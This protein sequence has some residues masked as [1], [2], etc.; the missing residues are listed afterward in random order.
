MF[1]NDNIEVITS[2][3]CF[4]LV[5]THCVSI[6]CVVIISLRHTG[7]VV[8]DHTHK[9]RP[10]D[11]F[12]CCEHCSGWQVE[13][14]SQPTSS[15]KSKDKMEERES[16]S[17]CYNYNA[18]VTNNYY[19][20]PSAPPTA[21]PTCNSNSSCER[22]APLNAPS[23]QCSKSDDESHNLKRKSHD[24]KHKIEPSEQYSRK[25]DGGRARTTLSRKST[26]CIGNG[27]AC[28]AH[29]P[30]CTRSLSDSS[31][32]LKQRCCV[33]HGECFCEGKLSCVGPTSSGGGSTTKS[34][35]EE[36]GDE[37]KEMANRLFDVF[38]YN[39]LRRNY[40]GTRKEVV[41]SLLV[42]FFIYQAVS[43]GL[44][45]ICEDGGFRAVFH[46]GDQNRYPEI[47]NRLL[48]FSLR[49]LFRVIL[50]LCCTVH[51]PILATT[52]FIPST[53]LSNKEIL[54]GLMR[55]HKCFS[56]EEEVAQL[57]S[58]SPKTVLSMSEEMVKR[59][60]HSMW[61]TATHSILCIFLIVY[62]G[63]FYVCEQN[64]MK[65]GMCNFLSVFIIHVPL[66]NFNFHFVIAAESFT[67]FLN[68]LIFG[69]VGDCYHYEN[70]IATYA[71]IIGGDAKKL[72]KEIRRRWVI[73]DRLV[74]VM[75]FVKA[76]ILALSISTGR[77]F[78][79]TPVTPVQDSDLADWYFW[80]MV[81]TVLFALGTSSIRMAKKA[82]IGGYVIAAM[83]IFTVQVETSHIP[84]GSI[85]VLLY[86]VM[87]VYILNHLF[88]LARCHYSNIGSCSGWFPFLM[89]MC[90]ILIL[91]TSVA[92]TIYREIALFSLFVVW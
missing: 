44:M 41:R 84:Y 14:P 64:T 79:S 46:S 15:K 81:L 12:K 53:N 65:G 89:I 49:L 80:I 40:H 70:R 91:L 21:T 43:A 75:P 56:S 19:T 90:L 3:K 73:M 37:L 58:S 42:V 88:G 92:V 38:P 71:T 8:A 34:H 1:Q 47:V 33:G 29:S 57:R 54:A 78:V 32:T 83:L 52:P 85:M 25:Q 7:H 60:I 30:P 55:I 76:A 13:V 6:M 9:T 39:F 67:V 2:S 77:P 72:F 5:T 24:L 68:I 28:K 48:K 36:K 61:I 69:V 16:S 26:F 62:L 63:A 4:C 10:S 87:S 35:S 45:T 74:Y 66:L 86:T 82:C 50:P 17:I 27:S 22:D 11:C 23:S 18:P 59:R 51:L 31:I 20:L